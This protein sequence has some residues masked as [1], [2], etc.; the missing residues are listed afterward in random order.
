M[1]YSGVTKK[2]KEHPNA[3]EMS[4]RPKHR[5]TTKLFSVISIVAIADRISTVGE[6][7]LLTPFLL[8]SATHS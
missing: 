4:M 3:D 2:G 8:R 1:Y 5:L 7:S 6:M